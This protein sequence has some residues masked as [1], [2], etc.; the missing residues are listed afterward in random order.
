MICKFELANCLKSFK[1]YKQ[2]LDHSLGTRGLCILEKKFINWIYDVNKMIWSI[3]AL[4]W[5]LFTL[6]VRLTE[7]D[8]NLKNK[9]LI[10]QLLI[11]TSEKND[12]R[13]IFHWAGGMRS[14]WKSV[15]RQRV[16][17][18]LVH[19]IIIYTAETG[20]LTLRMSLLSRVCICG[21]RVGCSTNC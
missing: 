17:H 14:T 9:K 8:K 7:H 13:F 3:W 18:N 6:R 15:Q 19:K 11:K 21:M 20:S 16:L 1:D 4:L 10:N 2:S 5:N 12:I